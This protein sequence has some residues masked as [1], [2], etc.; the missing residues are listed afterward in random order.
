VH[1]PEPH[2]VLAVLGLRTGLMAHS[3]IVR[4]DEIT[5]LPFVPVLKIK[6]KT[7][8]GSLDKA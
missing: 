2:L 1:D 8:M 3:Q 4:D 6:L 7:F 5:R